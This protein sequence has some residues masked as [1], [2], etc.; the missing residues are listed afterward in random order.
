MPPD[1]G[2]ATARHHEKRAFVDFLLTRLQP[3]RQ[4]RM[5]RLGLRKRHLTGLL[6]VRDAALQI[7]PPGGSQKVQIADP[8]VQTEPLARRVAHRQI[9]LPRVLLFHRDQRRHFRRLI[10]DVVRSNLD[11][12][13]QAERADPLLSSLNRAAAKQ[14]ARRVGH[15]P[16]NDGIVDAP[17]ARDVDAP[18]I[19]ERA[20]LRAHDDA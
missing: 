8:S 16:S 3:Q 13:E 17:I 4:L 11:R 12:L 18:E 19:P 14:V 2:L 15:P 1:R 20:R 6:D 9:P 7:E 10:V 5:P